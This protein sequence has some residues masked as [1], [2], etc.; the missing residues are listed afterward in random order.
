M[1]SRGSSTTCDDHLPTELEEL[2]IPLLNS[3]YNLARWLVGNDHDAEDLV[4]ET[5]LKAFSNFSS[6]QPGTNFRA[7]MFQILRNTFLNSRSKLDRRITVELNYKEPAH[8]R[9]DRKGPDSLLIEKTSVAAI[10]DA[11]ENLT[12]SSREVIL[13]CDVEEF[14]YREIAEF[15]GFRSEP[16]CQGSP[17]LEGRS[18]VRSFQ[19]GPISAGTAC[20][21]S[22]INIPVRRKG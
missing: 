16:L 14:A 9:S 2:A 1:I 4:P 12:S 6:F 8:L 20:R 3:A 7:W 5:Y 15:S 18:A 17:D 21:T 22:K 11:I 10:W 19:L 13:S